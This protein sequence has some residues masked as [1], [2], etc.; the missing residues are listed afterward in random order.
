M[1]QKQVKTIA[2]ALRIELIETDIRV[3]NIQPGI[4]KTD[5]SLVRFKGDKNK[6]D[7][8]Y[9]GIDAISQKMLLGLVSFCN[10][11]TK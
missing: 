4:V 6:A 1:L 5:F 10:I 2:D 8:V 11:S 3:T 7:S 9:D